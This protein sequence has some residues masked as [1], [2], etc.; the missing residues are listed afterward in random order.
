[1]RA[2]AAAAVLSIASGAAAQ[3]R[4]AG[5]PGADE[6]RTPPPPPKE[7][8]VESVHT[9]RIG[10]TDIR[11]RAVAGT[12]VLRD[13][14]GVPKASIFYVSYERT[15]RKDPAERP[16]TFSFNGGP[17]SSSV[18]LHLGLLG[19]KRV[20]LAEDGTAPPPPYRLVE[21]AY[22]LLDVSDLVFIDPVTTGYSRSAEG[23]DPK[24]F[25]GVDEDVRW[26]AEFIRLFTTR[27]GRWGSPK[28]LIGESYGTTRAAALAGH[29]QDEHGLFL[30]GVILISSILNFQT[31]DF[32]TGND[33]PY[34][35]F[36]PSYTATAWYH[37]ALGDRYRDD[38]GA[39]LSDAEAFAMGE[40][41]T[42]LMLGDVISD[43]MRT[44][45]ARRLSE[46]TGLSEDFIEK[47]DLRV[48]MGRF[49]KELLR[50]RRLTVGRLDSRFTGHDRDAAGS[51]PEFDPSYE[52]ILGPFTACMN[53]YV[54]R[55]LGFESDLPYEILTDKVRPWSY[56]RFSNRYI[57]VA[58]TL[59]AAMTRNPA[60]KV[61]VASGCFDLATPYLATRYT[62]DHL[63]LP[64]S[65]RG[66][67]THGFFEAGHMMYIHGPSL[68][69]LK[70]ELASFIGEASGR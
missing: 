35:L 26:V 51:R 24:Q 3:E 68:A 21:N 16:L 65:L 50:D 32:N 9:A 44:Q 47:S 69:R 28:F 62:F 33:L 4:A 40:Y 12:M 22:S 14:K 59:R 6:V 70:E 31:A 5:R 7:E 34:A 19:P 49:T 63:A 53:D 54:R 43:E 45:T 29:L 27:A 60:M 61:Y 8:R 56:G 58:E 38:L 1:M 17:G 37:G 13:E 20:E 42:A 67:I 66:N 23:E 30:N 39:A 18:W 36:L 15:D 2:A 41:S 57:D 55:E 10:G 48:R 64:V 52:N 46:L 11:Y 25:H